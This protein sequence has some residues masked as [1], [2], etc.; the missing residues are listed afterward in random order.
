MINFAICISGHLRTFSNLK[1]N[2]LEFLNFLKKHGNVDVFLTTWNFLNAH[3]YYRP[4]EWDVNHLQNVKIPEISE[5]QEHFKCKKLLTFD[6]NFFESE[7]S[8]LR[9][10]LLCS[11][12]LSASASDQ[13]NNIFHFCK[14]LFLINQCNLL[15]QQEEFINQKKYDVVFRI[16]PDYRF[17]LFNIKTLNV[18]RVKPNTLY[19]AAIHADL[20][21]QFLYGDSL[22]MD[23]FSNSIYRLNH[24]FQN[25]MTFNCESVIL[26]SIL[27]YSNIQIFNIEPAGELE[28]NLQ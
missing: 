16:R 15:K 14:M 23:V 4:S 9:W 10:N 7:Y 20:D 11:Q 28:R 8:P 6:Q 18:L 19:T 2:Y 1:K 13:K 12:D 26:E 25:K 21:D 3:I 17:N 24:L 22:S 27:K 5:I